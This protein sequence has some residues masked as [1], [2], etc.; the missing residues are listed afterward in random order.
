MDKQYFEDS[1][2]I[3]DEKLI[4]FNEKTGFFHDLE[5]I[6]GK[7]HRDFTGYTINK[8]GEKT[9]W[10]IELKNRK[11]ILQDDGRISGC[12]SKGNVYIDE[13]LYIENHKI[14][15]LL[16]DRIIGFEPLYINFTLNGYTIVYNLAKLTKRPEKTIKKNIYSKGYEKMED[17]RRQGLYL[18]DAAIFNKDGK[19]VKKS[20]EDFI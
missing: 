18:K 8:L 10:N 6:I 9:R 15:D 12:T 19:L 5:R 20:G 11:L 7:E 4:E 3:C 17:G 16:L 1:E 13:T 2:K 14:T